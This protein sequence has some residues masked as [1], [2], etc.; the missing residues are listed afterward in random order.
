MSCKD[1]S[2]ICESKSPLRSIDKNKMNNIQ[3]RLEAFCDQVPFSSDNVP[4]PDNLPLSC[5]NLQMKTNICDQVTNQT[6]MNK[7]KIAFKPS[8]D[9]V[10]N[11]SVNDSKKLPFKLNSNDEQEEKS[12][13]GLLSL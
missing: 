3:E 8:I 12:V 6:T 5:K 4:I 13:Q 1:S 11:S 10:P 7:V 9:D 2:K